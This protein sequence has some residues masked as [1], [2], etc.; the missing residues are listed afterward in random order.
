MIKDN[1]AGVLATLAIG[2]IG[3]FFY[4]LLLVVVVVSALYWPWWGA[5]IVGAGV[6]GV[7]GLG[8]G[9]TH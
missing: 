1:V 8:D 3:V 9:K 4:G 5:L 7:A 6:L 2:A